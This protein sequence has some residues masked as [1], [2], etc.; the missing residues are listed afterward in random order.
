M[1]HVTKNC[2]DK[3]TKEVKTAKTQ[4]SNVYE[5]P[6]EENSI[7]HRKLVTYEIKDS[8]IR[9]ILICLDTL[10]DTG[11]PVSFIKERFIEKQGLLPLRQIRQIA[12]TAGVSKYR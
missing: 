3:E 6:E 7:E 12:I 9:R 2:P 1:G 10:L 8:S 5:D 4:V 11:S